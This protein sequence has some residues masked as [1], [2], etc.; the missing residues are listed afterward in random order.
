MIQKDLNSI[1]FIKNKAGKL[2]SANELYDPNN[3]FLRELFISEDKF[4]EEDKTQMDLLSHLQFQSQESQAFQSDVVQTCQQIDSKMTDNTLRMRKSNALFYVFQQNQSLFIHVYNS[5]LGCKIIPCRENGDQFYPKKMKWYSSKEK[6][7][8]FEM[9][10]SSKYECIIGSVLP[11]PAK[12]WEYL[13]HLPREPLLEDVL[14]HLNNIIEDYHKDEHVEYCYITRNVYQFLATKTV[15]TFVSLLPEKCIF[16]ELGFVRI[17]DVFIER[18]STDLNLDPYYIP[19]PKELSTFEGFFEAIGCEKKQSNYLLIKALEKIREKQSGIEDLQGVNEDFDKVQK[20]LCRLS[21]FS[22]EDLSKIRDDIIV[23]IHNEASQ[24]LSF[25]KAHECAYTDSNWYSGTFTNETKI[26]LIHSKIDKNIAKKLGVKSLRKFALS[27]AEEII[28]EFGQSEPLTQRLN[29]LLEEGYTD[30][31]SVPKELI[32]N[33]DDA[34]ASEVYFLYDEREN[35]GARNCLLD[36]GMK[37][38]QG[39]ALWAYNNAAFSPSDFQNIQKLNGATKKEDTTKIG[40][41]GLGFNAVYNLTDVPSFVSGK[42][43]VYLDPHGKYLGEAI[44]N[45]KSPGIKLNLYN[46][47]MLYKFEDQFKPYENVFGFKSSVFSEDRPYKGTLFR[48]PLRTKQQA[49]TSKIKRKEYSKEEMVRL[50]KLFCKSCGNMI[51]FTQNVKT[52]KIFHNAK[53][54]INPGEEMKLIMTV[55]KKEESQLEQHDMNILAA[56]SRYCCNVDSNPSFVAFSL[57]NVTVASTGHFW[58]DKKNSF[59]ENTYWV[60]TWA[61]GHNQSLR[62]FKENRSDGAF[63]ISSVAVPVEIKNG[64]ITPFKLHG[65]FHRYGFYELGHLFC[66]LPLP[67]PNGMNFHING[68]FAI[69]SDRQRLLNQTEDDKDSTKQTIW[70][71]S[72]VTD[73]TLEAFISLLLLL[74]D[75]SSESYS[76]FALWPTQSCDTLLQHFKLKFYKAIVVRDLPL[77]KTYCGWK[78]FQECIFLH[79]EM[80]EDKHLKQAA[81]EILRKSPMDGKTLTEIPRDVYKE[82]ENHLDVFFEKHVVTYE[83]FFIDYFLPNI[84]MYRGTKYDKIVLQAIRSKNKNILTAIQKTDCIKTPPNGVRRAPKNL[85]HPH[86][87]LSGLFVI[88]DERF[89]AKIFYREDDLEVLVSLGMMKNEIPWDLCESQAGDVSELSKQCGECALQRSMHII[90][91]VHRFFPQ[92][93]QKTTKKL[94]NTSF[95]PVKEKPDGWP[96]KWHHKVSKGK[97]NKEKCA[98]HS[99]KGKEEPISFECPCNMFLPTCERLVGCTKI[100]LGRYDIFK[101]YV[102]EVKALGVKSE[103]YVELETLKHQLTEITNKIENAANKIVED[104]CFDIYTVLQGRVTEPDV[105]TFIRDNLSNLPCVLTEKTFAFPNQ[106]VFYLPQDCSPFFFGLKSRLAHN[107]L[108]LMKVLGVRNFV[109]PDDIVDVL[110]C[111]KENHSGKKLPR[112]K[113][114]LVCRIANLLENF[115]LL[116]NDNLYLP[117]VNGYFI[118][119]NELCLDDCAWLPRTESMKF[120]NTEITIKVAKLVGV[121]S[122]RE[123]NIFE[124]SEEFGDAFGQHEDLTNRINR[125]LDGYPENNIMKELLQN[126][127]DAGATEMHFIKDFRTHKCDY[128]F[129]ENWKELQGPA[130]CVFN[131]SVFTD[132]DFEGIQNLGIGSKGNDPTLTGQYG[133][134][135]NVVYHLTDVPSFLSRDQRTSQD[136]LCILD[137]HCKYIQRSTMEKPGRKFKNFSKNAKYKDIMSCYLYGSEL[138]T[139]SRGTLFRFPLRSNRES[140]LSSKLISCEDI[141]SLLDE[142][143]EDMAECLLFLHNVRCI[144]VSSINMEG[145]LSK[146]FSVSSKTKLISSIKSYLCHAI[147]NIRQQMK[148]DTTLICSME[149]KEVE[150]YLKINVNEQL[151]Q[152][153]LIVTGVGFQDKTKIPEIIKEAYRERRLALLPT[154]GIAINMENMVPV[155]YDRKLHVHKEISEFRAY[156]FL[157]LPVQTGLTVHLNGHFVLDHEARHGIWW[158][159]SQHTDLKIIWNKT[160]IKEVIVPTYALAIEHLRNLLFPES[161]S[162][163]PWDQLDKFHKVFPSMKLLKDKIWQYTSTELYRYVGQHNCKFFPIVRREDLNIECSDESSVKTDLENQSPDK[164]KSDINIRMHDQQFEV[165]WTTLQT[166][167]FD[168]IKWPLRQDH[169]AEGY[170]FTYGKSSKKLNESCSKDSEFLAQSLKN[171]GMLL[172]ETPLWVFSSMKDAGI[173]GVQIVSPKAVLNFLKTYK[174]DAQYKCKIEKVNIP[175]KQTR[176]K[177]KN[178]TQSLLSYCVRDKDLKA[179]DFEHV[180]LLITADGLLREF[181]NERVIYLIDFPE[182][183]PRS[184]NLIADVGQ[185]RILKSHSALQKIIKELDVSDFSELLQQNISPS[186]RACTEQSWNPESKSIP[187]VRW[188]KL[189]WFFIAQK[190]QD[191]IFDEQIREKK[192]NSEREWFQMFSSKVLQLFERWYLVPAI[193]KQNEGKNHFLFPLKHGK[194]VLLLMFGQNAIEQ[195]ALIELNLPLLD[196]T[197]LPTYKD[198]DGFNNC[199]IVSKILQ[200]LAATIANVEDILNCVFCNLARLCTQCNDSCKAIMKYFAQNLETLKESPGSRDKLAALPLYYSDIYQQCVSVQR[201]TVII[202]PEDVPKYGLVEWSKTMNTTFIE[203]DQSLTQLYQFVGCKVVTDVSFYIQVLLPNFQRLPPETVMFHLR[204]IKDIVIHSLEYSNCLNA[205]RQLT[206]LDGLLRK[207][208]FLPTESGRYARAC[209]FFNPSKDIFKLENCLCLSSELPSKPFDN[210]EWENFLIHCGMKN[211]FTPE[212]FLEFAIRLQNLGD[213]NGVTSIVLKNSRYLVRD[214]FLNRTDLLKNWS[215]VNDLKHVRFICPYKVSK[216]YTQIVEQYNNCNKLIC[217]RN[218]AIPTCDKLIWSVMGIISEETFDALRYLSRDEQVLAKRMLEIIDLPP[219]KNVVNHV[220]N[221]CFSIKDQL[222]QLL[223]DNRNEKA[224]SNVMFSVY[225]FLQKHGTDEYFALLKTVPFVF[226]KK[227]EILSLPQRVI[228]DIN[229]EEEI[230][231]YLCKAPVF[232]GQF[233]SLFRDCGAADT[234][235]CQ[236]L[237]NVLYEIYQETEGNE[238]EPNE[239]LKTKKTVQYL[240]SKLK[241]EEQIKIESVLYFPSKR[242]NLIQSDKMVFIDD[243]L[244]E[245]R[246]G[247]SL[248][249]LEFFVG[250]DELGMDVLDPLGEI[251]LL[252][253]SHRPKLMSKIFNEEM[254]RGCTQSAAFTE[255]ARTLQNFLR[256]DKCYFGVIRLVRDE[257]YKN[258]KSFSEAKQ[259]EIFQKLQRVTVFQLETLETVLMYNESILPNTEKQKKVFSEEIKDDAGNSVELRIYFKVNHEVDIADLIFDIDRKLSAMLNIYLGDPLKKNE[260]YLTDVLKCIKNPCKIEDELTNLEIMAIDVGRALTILPFMPDLGAEISLSLH[261]L[262]NNSCTYIEI[263]TYVAYE[264]YDPIID[265]EEPKNED[266]PVYILARIVGLLTQHGSHGLNADAWDM[267]YKID[268]GSEKALVAEAS[269]VYKF[270]R[271]E[272]ID[273]NPEEVDGAKV[274][275]WNIDNVKVYIRDVMRKAFKKSKSEFDRTMKRLILQHHPKNYAENKDYYVQLNKFIHFIEET[276]KKGEP[277]DD[278]DI[279]DSFNPEVIYPI[280]CFWVICDTRVNEYAK[281]HLDYS[282]S[283]ERKDAPF[284]TAFNER[285]SQPGQAK[286]WFKQADIDFKAAFTDLNGPN[287]YNWTCYKCHQAVEKALKALLYQIDANKVALNTHNLSSL[288]YLTEDVNLSGLVGRLESITGGYFQMRYPDAVPG[289]CI[290]SDLYTS[291]KATKAIEYASEILQTIRQRI[292][293]VQ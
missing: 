170:Y 16:T 276:L 138:W 200:T 280:T 98:I 192:T 36:P 206:H 10:Y 48:F 246:I 127:D 252:P 69:S 285:G 287:A 145:I 75:H 114:R 216:V 144:T 243:V 266:T 140:L 269:R 115:D 271:Q 223:M 227:R 68:S 198:Q 19:I 191:F 20:I 57:T 207:I 31:L 187:N 119:V 82:L 141:E 71:Y 44:V 17:K 167:F 171:L 290:P 242:H 230:L 217:F 61:L 86:S 273:E 204:Y 278:K 81:S 52:I 267:K 28:S 257:L 161:L 39:P 6:F 22:E 123:Q 4:P 168:G 241:K 218:S 30:G 41:F 222:P 109:D 194:R 256:S 151:F 32:Q 148:K 238:L 13:V 201:K 210:P 225:E 235:L 133:V 11:L 54:S 21:E 166:A 219:V 281:N 108:E 63:P 289:G 67:I 155:Q 128:V 143:K 60:I 157:P 79:W 107:F 213:L 147:A 232:Y 247:R 84:L 203:E 292:P 174:T 150:Y 72:L 264:V 146:E 208:P 97:S 209:D 132:K 190:F 160:L 117:D 92:V 156:C 142:L 15:S 125:I 65:D 70:N 188:I 268:V 12:A 66:F 8:S 178:V 87:S 35:E 91:Y 251:N 73:A 184:A 212:I 88:Q 7:V 286:R 40:K 101:S 25:R 55:Q 255:H 104:I 245:G 110:L 131:D 29:R 129:S 158:P 43:M 47:T 93:P 162:D 240:F 46:K 64:Q 89:P 5:I 105:K 83:K 288:A 33:A 99:E 244:I 182:L 205:Q 76:Y 233:H 24:C 45:E 183:L 111:I 136:T 196:N 164:S 134:G 95:L 176:M 277:V 23:P 37:G 85:I 153:W 80:E 26:C 50:I 272:N 3:K 137:P 215:F 51:L 18:N 124:E 126:A 149:R 274:L 228:L 173:D 27:D 248:P 14:M 96:V 224:V 78:R 1:S 237:V 236:H 189:F 254:N 279:F 154:S 103:T 100:V 121:K 291:D 261:H 270:V 102:R 282:G 259:T 263:G 58:L 135:F 38:C 116:S 165:T 202:L 74:K 163:Q 199:H 2:C 172:I 56:A 106:V 186:C 42:Y 229:D 177:H 152:N 130:L 181:R 118:H 197:C 283:T 139:S 231:P 239:I 250:F 159:D 195:K 265:E 211:E 49:R 275:K 112:N 9:V 175:V 62:L 179:E 260:T 221:I 180:P 59:T 226:I 53:N 185:M 253:E 90:K 77:F 113:L 262:L 258:G 169:A 234:L 94:S 122:K 293:S 120:L 220:T 284:F 34:G 193:I 249:D 214:L